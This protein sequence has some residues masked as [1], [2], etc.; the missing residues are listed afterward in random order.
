MSDVTVGQIGVPPVDTVRNH[1]TILGHPAGLFVLFFT[2]MWERFSYYGMRALLV[3]Y[4]ISFLLPGIQN[5]TIHVIGFSALRSGIE[6][7]FGPMG[8]QPL[9]SQIYG[10]YTAFVYFT[11]FFGGMLADRVLGQRKAVVIGGI[12]IA[13]GQFLL[14][15]PALFLPGLLFLILG[16]GCFKPNISTQV[17]SLYPQGDPRRDRAFTIFYMGINLGAFFSPLICGTLG[18]R[19]GWQYGFGAAGVGMVGGLILYLWGQRYLA[20]DNLTRA[21]ETPHTEKAPLTSQEW[22][23]IIGLVV[24]CALNIIF[25]GVYEQQGNTIQIF[26]DKNTDWHI[27]GFEMPSTW[28]QAFNPMFI[29]LC[30]PLLNMLWNRQSIRGTEPASVTKMGIGCVL[31]GL[32]FLPL[33]YV[34]AGLQDTAKVSF[35]WLAFATL[36]YTIGELYLSP[37]GLSLVTKVAPARLVSMLMGMW[38][39]SSFFGNYLEGYL[40]TFYSKMTREAYFSMLAVLAVAAGLAIFA[41]SKPLKGAVGHKN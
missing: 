12:G 31:L 20:Q 16:N 15:S 25:W 18:Q 28:F 4:M 3:L 13:I 17:G 7:V 36:I 14:A 11:P 26:A 34:S 30:A 29:F 22:K 24:L 27:F 1:K 33:M 2:E 37:I 23:G 41:L 35:L 6:G 39:L 10:L 19:V 5:G 9:S 8:I 40:G 38:F 32:G 21:K